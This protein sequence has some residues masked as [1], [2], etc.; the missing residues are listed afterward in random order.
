MIYH[1]EERIMQVVLNL[2]SNALKFTNDGGSVK[3]H[4]HIIDEIEPEEEDQ[5]DSRTIK[6][7]IKQLEVTVEDTGV[8]I[9]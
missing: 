1:D 5:I 2:Q 3:I 8:G 7:P 4:V 9:S 6:I